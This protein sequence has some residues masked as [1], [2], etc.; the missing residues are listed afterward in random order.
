ME[1]REGILEPSL[2]TATLRNIRRKILKIL[3]HSM[4]QILVIGLPR[5]VAQHMG[6]QGCAGK[7]PPMCRGGGLKER[8]TTI[9]GDITASV[10]TSTLPPAWCSVWLQPPLKA[11]SF[12]STL[13]PT[14]L[15]PTLPWRPFEAI[16]LAPPYPPRP[17]FRSGAPWGASLYASCPN[18]QPE[19]GN[20]LQLTRRQKTLKIPRGFPKYLSHPR[21]LSPNQKLP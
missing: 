14:R 17:L 20:K 5:E 19:E 10:H 2:V 18:L 13:A 16:P 8:H 11:P 4:S 21:H 12:S 6:G 9:L 1:P 3:L 7:N 15:G